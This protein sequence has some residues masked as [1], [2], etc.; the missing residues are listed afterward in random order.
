VIAMVRLGRDAPPLPPHL[1][2]TVGLVAALGLLTV[3]AWL[4]RAQRA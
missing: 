3:G 4:C 1:P 2:G